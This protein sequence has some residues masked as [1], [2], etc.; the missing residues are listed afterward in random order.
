MVRGL[1]QQSVSDA[2]LFNFC[3]VCHFCGVYTVKI[4]LLRPETPR[5]CRAIWVAFFGMAENHQ[6]RD[7]LTPAE[8]AALFRVDPKTVTRWAKEGMLGGSIKTP[9][10]HRRFYRDVVEKYLEEGL[11]ELQ[12][13][14]GDVDDARA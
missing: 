9:G 1:G 11:D 6:V 13:E 14:T 12:E 2:T 5:H 10:G 4:V 7:I 8:V 3:H